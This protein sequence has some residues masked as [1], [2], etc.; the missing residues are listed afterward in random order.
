MAVG[1]GGGRGSNEGVV[2]GGEGG[3]T[4]DPGHVPQQYLHSSV[5]PPAPSSF[6]QPPDQTEPLPPKP[7][8]DIPPTPLLGEAAVVTPHPAPAVP[9]HSD[10]I[11]AALHSD[12]VPTV[13]H[14][15][16][17]EDEGSGYDEPA[18]HQQSFQGH[19]Q[20]DDPDPDRGGREEEGEGY[21]EEEFPHE[22]HYFQRRGDFRGPSRGDFRPH[23]RG[24]FHNPR[25]RGGGPR[26]FQFHGPRHFGP[27]G[28]REPSPRHWER[29]GMGFKG[30]RG[31]T[32][33]KYSRGG[34]QGEDIPPFDRE[35]QRNF[36][37][38]STPAES[39]FRPVPAPERSSQHD[40]YVR[41][42]ESVKK[43]EQ[44]KEMEL[45]R[46]LDRMKELERKKQLEIEQKLER[47]HQAEMER[48]RRMEEEEK[49][50]ARVRE[51]ELQKKREIELK[52]QQ[53]IEKKRRTME[54]MQERKQQMERELMEREEALE[55]SMGRGG[56]GGGSGSGEGGGGGIGEGWSGSNEQ[57]F[58]QDSGGAADPNQATIPSWGADRARIPG[59]GDLGEPTSSKRDVQ[60]RRRA[61]GDRAGG[62]GGGGGGGEEGRDGG[63]RGG[64]GGGG[65]GGD[66]GRGRAGLKQLPAAPQQP[67]P[68][69]EAKGGVQATQVME[70][71]GKIVSQ[72]QTLQGL[73]TSLKL[74][75]T[76][77]KGKES[78]ADDGGGK[79]A[80]EGVGKGVREEAG[81]GVRQGGREEGEG[82]AADQQER[83]LTEDTKR[84]VA[85]LLANESDSDGEQVNTF[86]VYSCCLL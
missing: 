34:P 67:A 19:N 64:D 59:F 27:H 68:V 13:P 17:R 75:R 62:E 24:T 84:K 55:R 81:A 22:R 56:G 40:N 66:A 20:F 2:E 5:E 83:E 6:V 45:K 26:G 61:G 72:L 77:P 43:R 38:R 85:A 76:L 73:T 31:P 79:S 30:H 35:K 21:Q 28:E 41:Q 39:Q 57:Y 33:E 14:S 54:M 8:F 36:S 86:A 44:Q 80:P 60:D 29:G 74:L 46:E 12:V 71:L 15:D 7:L 1:G 11:P 42:L 58:G 78:T 48:K 9:P 16:V 52:L 3:M 23:M 18:Y 49:K 32:E 82:K 53:E 63:R 4:R 47:E 10:R 50:R 25:G 70:S 37:S 51:Q 65:G 69:T